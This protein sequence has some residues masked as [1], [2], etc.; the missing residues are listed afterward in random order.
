MSKRIPSYRLHKPSLSRQSYF[1]SS[2]TTEAQSGFG[3]SATARL[4][5]DASTF[6]NTIAIEITVFMDGS[7]FVT[8]APRDYRE[9]GEVPEERK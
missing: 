2:A 6:P 1:F 8:E 4:A 7:F 3:S 9:V 5:R